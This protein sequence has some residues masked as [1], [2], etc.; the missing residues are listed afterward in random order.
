MNYIALV[1]LKLGQNIFLT[2][3]FAK[4]KF[5]DIS[6]YMGCAD[7]LKMKKKIVSFN[8]API[9]LKLL[10]Y[11]MKVVKNLTLLETDIYFVIFFPF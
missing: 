8:L 10:I 1:D 6:L 3:E 7:M 9:P 2:M 5:N 11:F 4:N